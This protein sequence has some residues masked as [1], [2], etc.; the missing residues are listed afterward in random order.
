MRC[1]NHLLREVTGY[2]SVCGVFGCADCVKEHEGA[3]YCRKHFK[4]IA[5]QL[6]KQKRHEE[7]LA[8]PER[9]RLV[10]H[11]K[12]AQTSYGVCF[13]M[14]HKAEGFHLDL[15]DESGEPLGKTQYYPFEE[16]KAVFYVKTFDGK[17]DP[18]LHYREWH[19]QGNE[20]VV[21]FL[22]GEMLHGHTFHP[23]RGT[24]PRFYVV[25]SDHTSNNISVLVEKSAIRSV[26]SPED[27]K[28]KRQQE[29]EAFLK[30]HSLTGRS[31]EE[32]VGDFHFEH[33]E[34]GRAQR[35]Y[36]AALET[37]EEARARL[38]K[39]LSSTHFN[40]GV[41]HIKEHDYMRAYACMK[42]ALDYDP[43]NERVKEKYDKLRHYLK[44][45]QRREP[46]SEGASL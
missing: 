24:D 20:V 33:R 27:Y 21:E 12:E 17:P 10:V 6:D 41:R 11:T 26:L 38:R 25:P 2:C 13:A 42:S 46:T 34:Y 44:K 32:L 31:R 7:L 4:P 14:N 39:K 40:I 23:Y 36:Q 1:P 9:Q 15:M 16:I 29:L 8:K 18:N 5:D 35:H 22:D 3:L 28:E 30:E 45:K 37:N 43:D 19:P